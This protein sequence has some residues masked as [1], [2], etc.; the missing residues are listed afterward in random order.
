MGQTYSEECEHIFR[1]AGFAL[2]FCTE[3]CTVEFWVFLIPYSAILDLPVCYFYIHVVLIDEVI[4]VQ[5]GGV[6]VLSLC[7]SAAAYNKCC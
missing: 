2:Y 1:N 3:R 4:L 5:N 6:L 7:G